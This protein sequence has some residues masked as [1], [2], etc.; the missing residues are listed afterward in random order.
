LASVKPNSDRPI[1]F[2]TDA[3]DHTDLP[4]LRHERRITVPISFTGDIA[5]F[6][7]DLLSNIDAIV[8][9]ADA[10]TLTVEFVNDR[11]RDLLGHEPMD[12]VAVPGF[13][14]ETIV[15]PDDRDAFTAAE[16]E[17]LRRGV[18]RLAI[19]QEG[20]RRVRASPSSASGCCRRP[21]PTP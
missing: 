3:A 15:H 18:S 8:W 20:R 19:D 10:D 16:Q 21:R 6:L 12:M 13:W 17:V 9:E 1:T 7:F 2:Q 4:T 5:G 11:V 14:A